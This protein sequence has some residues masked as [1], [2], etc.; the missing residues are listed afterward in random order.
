MKRP[1]SQ[2]RRP[3]A[4][5]PEWSSYPEA[6][7]LFA[8]GS[9]VWVAGRVALVVGTILS[10]ANQGSVIV[11]GHSTWVTWVRVGVNYATPFVVASLGYLAGC[12]TRTEPDPDNERQV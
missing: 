4:R 1:A 11:D 8:R 5:R 2:S 6:L 10:A 3:P 9:T 12:R 7:A